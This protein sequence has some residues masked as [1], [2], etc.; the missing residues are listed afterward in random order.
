MNMLIPIA[1]RHWKPLLALN[2]FVV[3]IA[4]YAMITSKPKWQAKAQL[5]V[6]NSSS[7]LNANLGKLGNVNDQG[8]QF[9]QQLNP[10]NILSSIIKSNEA[11][12]R[13]RES[14]PEKD[15][16][17]RLDL[18]Q[19]LFEVSPEGE[20]TII[21]IM[22]Q[23]STPELAEQRTK[24]LI[25]VFQQRLNEL[26]Q[27]N[28]Q[29]RSQFL[30]KEVQQALDNYKK[31]QTALAKFKNSSG[32]V[33]S[34]T[35]ANEITKSI[36]GLKT[37]QAQTLS[38]AQSRKQEAAVLSAKLGLT[39]VKAVQSLKL[40]ENKDYQ[41][42]QQ[43]ITEIEVALADTQ[44]KYLPSHPTVISLL[45]QRQ[46]LVNIQQQTLN[47]AATEKTRNLVVD[48]K[49][50]EDSASLIQQLII[51]ESQ[52]SGLQTQANYLG[53][54]INRF[55]AELNAFPIKQARLNALQQQLDI[56]E[57][58]YNGVVARIKESQL[59]AF[60]AYPSVQV[61]DAPRIGSKPIGGGKRIIALGVILAS[62]F[63]SIALALWLESRNPLL[64]TRDLQT[65]NI[66][67]LISI[68][69]FKNFLPNNDPRLDTA[70]EYQR[71][72]SAISMISLPNNRLLISSATQGEGK[73]TVTMGLA[74]ALNSLGFRI[75][76]VDA[77]VHKNQLSKRLGININNSQEL[78]STPIS[79]RPNIDLQRIMPASENINKFIARGSFEKALNLAQTHNKYDYVLIDS[80]PLSLTNEALF[81]TQV[82]NNVLLVVSPG[83]SYRNPFNDS[84]NQLK[85]HQ[86]Q[87]VGLVV[88][89]VE[90]QHEGYLY[91]QQ[92]TEVG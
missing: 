30:E 31:A 11:I 26:R 78:E 87:I 75:L 60:S 7:D 63:G 25:D 58:V 67:V 41:Y 54:Q 83:N 33:S 82:V 29:Q 23:G 59:N 65:V 73:T 18:Y 45:E 10:L 51:A 86:T 37:L 55:I 72:A 53:S 69:R 8:V 66:P 15:E 4:G 49:I 76:V 19:D 22:A 81:M 32:L 71:L 28:A 12:N 13:V 92:I 3:V 5:I 61:L 91:E 16:Y 84:I 6:P 52:A 90:T 40:K 79:V 42:I 68:P 56:A 21:S 34:E 14:D 27:N 1:L 80:P 50:G 39:P 62:G 85:R 35:Q 36:S 20:S 2:L 44:T 46:K 74:I 24:A 57:G 88:N 48:N 9:S 47:Q 70:I 64:S 77:D 89:G 38:Q 17:P 43:K